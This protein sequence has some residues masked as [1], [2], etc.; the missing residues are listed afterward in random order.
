MKRYG[1]STQ[2]LRAA[3]S[4]KGMILEGVAIVYNQPT[5]LFSEDGIDY[6]EQISSR[7]LDGVDLSDVPL[8]YNH[9]QGFTILART[10]NQSLKLDNR[11]DGLHFTAALNPEVQSHKDVYK[12]VRS[13]LVNKMSFGFIVGPD[14]DDYDRLQHLRTVM[15]IDRLYDVSIVDQPAYE[16]TTVEARN[17]YLADM[18]DNGLIMIRSR[19]A[20]QAKIGKIKLLMEE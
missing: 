20:I 17:Q 8:R 14:G 6:K 7:A 19:I 3:D 11:P 15:Q 4:A 13:G 9:D 18:P 10:R 5:I 2:E 12:L 16:Q 1:I